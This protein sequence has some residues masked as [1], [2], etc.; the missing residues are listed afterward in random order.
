[1]RAYTSAGL[2]HTAS[3]LLKE[4][5]RTVSRQQTC[6]LP[7]TNL[8][9]CVEADASPQNVTATA[10][11]STEIE[12][13]AIDQNGVT[14]MYE[15]NYVTLETFEGRISTDI[16]YA[17]NGTILMFTLNG[18]EEYVEYNNSVRAYTSAGTGPYSV[19]VVERTDTD[20]ELATNIVYYILPI[21]FTCRT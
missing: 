21:V 15:I 7:L 6:I 2:D 18:L 19:G 8:F 20:G 5:I 10:V 9:S 11:S 12:V 3:V 1:M 14:T 16:C 4:Q 13:P 17:S